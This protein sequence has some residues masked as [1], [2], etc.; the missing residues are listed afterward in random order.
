M[1]SLHNADCF[2]IL[3]LI[4]DQSV[5]LAL[6]DLPFGVTCA[7]WD[8]KISLERFWA[9]MERIMIPNLGVVLQFGTQPFTSEL[10]MSSPKAWFKQELIWE[11]H[12]PTGFA[13]CSQKIMNAHENIL[14][15]SSGVVAGKHQSNRQ[16]L[17]N[18]Q[19]LVELETPR[20]RKSEQRVGF[21][22]KKFYKGGVQKF[23][24]YPRSV[25]KYNSVHK[26]VHNTQKPTDLLEYLILTY[27][28]PGDTVLDPTMG[29]GS[30]GVAAKAT[31]RNFIGIEMNEDYFNIA[32]SRI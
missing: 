11:K 19:G 22:G 30:T 2:D 31:D 28:N 27:S 14:V 1:I 12:R 20:V 24:N 7:K 25:L 5:Q 15:F 4:P 16:M 10:I 26:P 29:S 9:E 6:C 17:Y 23:T 13:Q 18:P 3:P 8:K 32:H 21:L